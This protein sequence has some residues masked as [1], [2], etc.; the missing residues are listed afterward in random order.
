MKKILKNLLKA[1]KVF[2]S[3]S[4]MILIS[5]FIKIADKKSL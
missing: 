3:Y 4:P 1:L 2:I 5:E